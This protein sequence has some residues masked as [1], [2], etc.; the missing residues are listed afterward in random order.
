M[1]NLLVIGAGGHGR[2]VADAAISSGQFDTVGFLDDRYEQCKSA[3]GRPVLG[4]IADASVFLKEF[5]HAVIAIG[6]NGLRVELIYRL[7]N[8]GFHMP[9]IIHPRAC[10][11]M[12]VKLGAGSVVLANAVVNTGSVLGTGVII[13]TGATVDHD[14]VLGDGVHISPGA[15][16]AGEVSVGAYSWIGTGANITP[17]VQVGERTIVGAGAVVIRTVPD[18]VTVVGMP[19]HILQKRKREEI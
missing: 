9:A 4:S 2:V 15:H 14:N 8:L 17:Q 19:A 6:D 3:L 16:L 1:N 10:I 18:G 11:G 5:S 7:L 12:D 13:N